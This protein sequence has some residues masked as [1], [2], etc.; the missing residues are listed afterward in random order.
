MLKDSLVKLMIWEISSTRN[1]L[2][3]LDRVVNVSNYN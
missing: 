1:L 2:Y 3:E